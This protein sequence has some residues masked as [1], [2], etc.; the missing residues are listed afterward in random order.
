MNENN[1]SVLD[2]A[3]DQLDAELHALIGDA[4][5]SNDDAVET[6]A[7]AT[8][9]IDLEELDAAAAAETVKAEAY[10]DQSA[11]ESDGTASAT[12]TPISAAKRSR[13]SRAAGAKAF[14]VLKGAMNDDELQKAAMLVSGDADDPALVDALRDTVNGLA[15]KVGDKATNL[16]RHAGNPA[17]LQK[18][19]S[20]GLNYLREKGSF[21]SKDLV[22]HYQTQGYTI[23]TA[24]SQANQIMTL[25]PA[26]KVAEKSGRVLT[27]REDSSLLASYE[28]ALSAS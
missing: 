2:A 10:A 13:V 7:V 19:T 9:E 24:R 11:D 18:F 23:G 21:S 25:L 1:E 8:E 3:P 26:L 22:D 27:K 6:S 16:L 17:K 12:V 28:G 4:T 20:I 5:A 15:K 14:D